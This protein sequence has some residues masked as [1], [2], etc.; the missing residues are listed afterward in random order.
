[1]LWIGRR[2]KGRMKMSWLSFYFD[3]P[4]S[5]NSSKNRDQ[6]YDELIMANSRLPTDWPRS[7][8]CILL[9]LDIDGFSIKYVIKS[10]QHWT[11]LCITIYTTAS[12]FHKF[13]RTFVE[14]LL[15][16]IL[17]LFTFTYISV[18]LVCS[19]YLYLHTTQQIT[20]KRISFLPWI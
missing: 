5:G 1:M 17:Q 9:T 13:H 12:Q 19:M 15:L 11:L 7:R 6:Y 10:L 18:L 2:T 14:Y 3:Y 8:Y 4:F 20:R 16:C